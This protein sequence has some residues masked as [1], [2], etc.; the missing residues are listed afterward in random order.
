MLNGKNLRNIIL[1]LGNINPILD[2][3][4]LYKSGYVFLKKEWYRENTN[5]IFLDDN[6]RS[7]MVV[8]PRVIK[9]L[10]PPEYSRI[11]ERRLYANKNSF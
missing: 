5:T 8:V 3:K 6:I 7:R 9:Q 10:H 1:D 11:L 4:H 2:W